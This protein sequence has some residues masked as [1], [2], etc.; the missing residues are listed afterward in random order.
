M[1]EKMKAAVFYEQERMEIEEVDVPLISESEVLI[2]IK[3][4]GICGSDISYYYGKSPLE[5][6]TGKGP[7]ILGHEISGEIVDAGREAIKFYRPGDRVTLNPPQPCGACVYCRMARPNLC[8][9]TKTIGV[10][11]HGGF[12]E[13]V[14]VGYANVVKIPPSVDYLEAAMAEPLACA[15][16]GVKKLDVQP[17]DFVVV[18]GSGS[19]GLMMAQLVKLRGASKVLLTGTTDFRL[20]TAKK[21]GV[22]YVYNTRESKSLYYSADIRGIV[23]ELSGGPGAGR[24]I[25]PVASGTAYRDAFRVSAKASTIVFFGL[26]G[27]KDTIEVP[28]LETLTG[29]KSVLFA[30]LAPYTWN[31]AMAALSSGTVQFRPLITHTFPL[32]KTREGIEFMHSPAPEKIKGM[33]VAKEIHHDNP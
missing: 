16:Y 19:I 8:E 7:L 15:C 11:I 10:S 6:P 14:K 4:C 29:D 22:D 32:E 12:A 27:D 13:Y 24:V 1:G 33:I 25:V 20:E 23:R 31:T 3:A 28:A 5:T 17:G 2:K 9:H 21:I 30:W 26:P 18:I